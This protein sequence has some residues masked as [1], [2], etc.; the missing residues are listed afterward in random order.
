MGRPAEPLQSANH[1]VV[2]TKTG[3]SLGYGALA[4]LAAQLPVPD[5]KSVPL[6]SSSFATSASLS[7]SL[8][9]QTSLTEPHVLV[10][11]FESLGCSTRS[12]HG[13]PQSATK[14]S[15]S[16]TRQHLAV[17]GVVRI[18]KLPTV[19]LPTA[20][21]PLGGV[22]VVAENTWAAFRGREAL[23]IR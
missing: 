7:E 11:M 18:I 17:P 8:T 6:K 3:A 9:D 1:Q 15:R 19:N 23:S 12:L 4:P 2:N 5:A 22:A 20:F 13:H 16:Q 10:P 14:S 21:A